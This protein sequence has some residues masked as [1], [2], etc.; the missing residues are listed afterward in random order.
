M[1]HDP[2]TAHTLLGLICSDIRLFQPSFSLWL[3][4]PA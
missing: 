3:E 1:M 4:M 2:L